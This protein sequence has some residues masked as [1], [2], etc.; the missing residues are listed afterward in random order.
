[1]KV[2]GV[3]MGAGNQVIARL[4]ERG[5]VWAGAHAMLFVLDKFF[6]FVLF[7]LAIIGL[8]LLWGTA[9]M[10]AVSLVNCVI[11]ILLYDRLSSTRFRD[12][13][14]LESIKEAATAAHD[15]WLARWT[16]T[17]GGHGTRLVAKVGLFLYLSIWFDPMTCVIFMR[18]AGQYLMTPAYWTVFGLSVVI[19]NAIWG[20]LVYTGVETV[21]ALLEHVW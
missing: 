18:P 9:T 13:L 11:L 5:M 14:G 3:N 16:K 8:G 21:S 12:A 4:R 2:A 20:L 10:M 17:G 7:P 19:S 6:D 15:S 1:M